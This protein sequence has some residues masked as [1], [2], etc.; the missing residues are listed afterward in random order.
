MFGTFEA[1]KADVKIVYGLVDQP[2][3]WNPVKHQIFY[4]GKVWEK[5]KTM[6]TWSDFLAAFWK[7]PG[8]FPGTERL[9]DISFV[10]ETPVR[11]KYD[12]QV[13]PLLHLYTLTHFILS[14]IVSDYIN[15]VSKVIQLLQQ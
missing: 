6:K 5:A 11:E 13:S 15:S 3:F 7:G 12:E 4:Y 9:G 8:W 14:F 1:E 2:Q 10:A